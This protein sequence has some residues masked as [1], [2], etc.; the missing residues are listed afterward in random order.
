MTELI[1]LSMLETIGV[2]GSI[3]SIASLLIVARTWYR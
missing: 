2:A 3:A 1:S